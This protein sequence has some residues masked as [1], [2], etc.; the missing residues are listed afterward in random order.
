M[1]RPDWDTYFLK[2]AKVVAS[3]STCLRI[4]D[5]VGAVLVRNTQVLTTGYAGSIRGADHCTDVGCLIDEK[6]GGCTRTIH[7]EINAILQAA[8]HGVRIR[9]ATLYTTMSPCWDCFKSILNGGVNRIVYKVEYR[10]VERQKEFARLS[11]IPFIH[12][13]VQKYIP[14]GN[15]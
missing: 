3:R 9:R 11:D 14:G 13:G 2:I 6:T 5:G 7:A 10:D 4:P 15:L 12:I 1:T 8:Q